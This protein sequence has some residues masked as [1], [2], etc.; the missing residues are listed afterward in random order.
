ML[1]M[2]SSNKDTA[3]EF[4]VALEEQ[5][6]CYEKVY[7]HEIFHKLLGKYKNDG[8]V[9]GHILRMINASNKLKHL[10]CELRTSSSS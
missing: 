7:A 10:K 1:M 4:M 2:N 5:F 3:K 9:R 6:K 8:D